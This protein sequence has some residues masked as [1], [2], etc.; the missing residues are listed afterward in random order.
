MVLCASDAPRPFGFPFFRFI[1]SFFFLLDQLTVVR[2]H[3][4]VPDSAGD[5]N[6]SMANAKC[7]MPR[8]SGYSFQIPCLVH[9]SSHAM[10]QGRKLKNGLE[11]QL[12]TVKSLDH[13]ARLKKQNKTSKC[14]QLCEAKVDSSSYPIHTP[15]AR[16]SASIPTPQSNE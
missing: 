3:R 7:K 12:Q 14:N 8:Q 13:I 15:K 16:H 2:S 1:V 6:S 5:R 9:V 10:N 4:V 11:V